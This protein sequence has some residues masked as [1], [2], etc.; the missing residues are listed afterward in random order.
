MYTEIWVESIG[1]RFRILGV[2]SVGDG[3]F[4]E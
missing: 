3:D 2:G 4:F 1:C